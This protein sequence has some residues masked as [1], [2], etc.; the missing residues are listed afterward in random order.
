MV[1]AQDEFIKTKKFKI[2][3]RCTADKHGGTIVDGKSFADAVNGW[4]NDNGMASLKEALKSPVN[5][6]SYL[7]NFIF[8]VDS[9]DKESYD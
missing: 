3:I 5:D 9:D 7:R 4:W 8:E 2:K 6:K 1:E